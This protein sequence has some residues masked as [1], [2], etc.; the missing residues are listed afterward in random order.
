M[1]IVLPNISSLLADIP[2][3]PIALILLLIFVGEILLALEFFVIP[4]F[5]A[6]GIM[7]GIALISAAVVAGSTYGILW[8]VA[9][10]VAS[11]I[12]SFASILVGMKTRIIQKRFVLDTVQNRGSGTSLNLSDLK[13]KKGTSIT[14]LRPSGAARIENQRVDVVTEGGFVDV[15]ATVEVILVEGPRVVVR[16]IKEDLN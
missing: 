3:S 10:F 1:N 15:G 8:G 7:G 16:E 5:G 14:A 9:V 12:L 4:G 6:G 2:I 11:S 13:G